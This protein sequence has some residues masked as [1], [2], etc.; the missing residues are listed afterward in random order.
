MSQFAYS[1]DNSVTTM[2]R[3]GAEDRGTAVRFPA[4]ASIQIQGLTH[5][6]DRRRVN[7]LWGESSQAILARPLVK[8]CWREGSELGS[9]ENKDV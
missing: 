1:R 6:Q 4:Q 8:I 3:I 2:T 5:P 7:T 9:A